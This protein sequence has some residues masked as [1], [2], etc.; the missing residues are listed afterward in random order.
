[1]FLCP[2]CLQKLD[3]ES[4]LDLYCLEHLTD[5]PH[6]I[7]C[8]PGFEKNLRCPHRRCE[9]HRRFDVKPI[10]LIHQG[11][12]FQFPYDKIVDQTL[13]SA[14]IRDGTATRTA[15]IVHWEAA[16]L[17]ILARRFKA[18]GPMFFPLA[19][20][21]GASQERRN[22][23]RSAI[24]GISGEV[25]VGKTVLTLQMMTPYGFGNRGSSLDAINT[26][27]YT[28]PRSENLEDSE[29]FNLLHLVPDREEGLHW[30]SPPKTPQPPGVDV[31]NVNLRAIFFSPRGNRKAGAPWVNHAPLWKLLWKEVGQVFRSWAEFAN[32]LPPQD[33]PSLL[34][35]DSPGEDAGDP[36]HPL[37]YFD[38]T[39]DVI[40]VVVEATDIWKPSAGDYPSLRRAYSR[41]KALQQTLGTSSTARTRVC[42]VVTK[43]D[44]VPE[45]LSAASTD[46]ES[47]NEE[48]PE[49][50]RAL[51]VK[52]LKGDRNGRPH[53]HADMLIN[54]LTGQSA[55]HIERVFMTY[56]T[57]LEENDRDTPET[58]GLSPF[59]VW[60]LQCDPAR[61]FEIPS[62]AVAPAVR[63]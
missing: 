19:A 1:M 22:R 50:L 55:L 62:A 13:L 15:P 29:L 48:A 52:S 54:C 59:V 58:F 6:P 14:R 34:I 23:G 42:L 46:A 57:N 12:G 38:R 40:A 25:S 63:T 11:C 27:I 5:E 2:I 61:L 49:R 4:R 56:T 3:E 53:P 44:L 51:L 33:S 24:V 32:Q 20:L 35:Y 60:C 18:A 39:V 47:L 7:T 45:L 43:I 28:Q 41:L 37:F 26:F 30:R 8:T 9:A 16:I 21:M 36:S 10:I 31:R 17:L